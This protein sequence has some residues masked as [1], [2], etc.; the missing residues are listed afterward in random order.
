MRIAIVNWSNRRIGGTGTYLS[1]VVPRLRAAGHEIALWHEVNTPLDY[2]TIPMPASAPVWSMSELGLDRALAALTA[3][4]PDVLYAHGLLDPAVERRTLDIAPSVFFAHNYYGTCIS[5]AKTFR[6]PSVRPCG[7]KFGWQCL[8]HYYP[9]RC[10]GWNPITMVQHYRQQRDRLHLLSKYSAIVTH[11]THMQKEYINHG[12]N[13]SRVFNVKYAADLA[14]TP[15]RADV[16]EGDAGAGSRPW[17][18]LFVGR[19]DELKGGRELIRALP[20]VVRRLDRRVRLT[21]AGDGPQRGEW[22]LLASRINRA[23]S[24]AEIRFFG[25]VPRQTVDGLF[26][27]SDLLVLPSL[28]PEPLALVGLEAAR[29][30]LPVAAFAVGGVSDWLTSGHNGFLASGDPP[31]IDGLVGAI[32]ACLKDPTTHARLREGAGSLSADF[33]FERHVELLLRAFADTAKS[34]STSTTH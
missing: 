20:D 15:A 25:W 33:A 27:Q 16:V 6:Q 3:W 32:T 13:T 12:F 2:D 30:R 10:G 4:R 22:E 24:R 29:H 34:R 26:A 11:S 14:E 28:W 17:E 18:L 9:R 7:R 8:A 1:A 21:F 19:M 23:E 31:T 5:G